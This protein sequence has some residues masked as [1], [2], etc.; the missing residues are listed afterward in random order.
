MNKYL[1]YL[2]RICHQAIVIKRSILEEAG[3]FDTSLAVT[4]DH[5]LILY[6]VEQFKGFK[7]PGVLSIY[8]GGGYSHQQPV[9]DTERRHFQR[10][11]S[12]HYSAIEL[13]ILNPLRSF[14]DKLAAMKRNRLKKRTRL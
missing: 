5:L 8:K 7:I 13:A 3:G 2:K 4:A 9:T 12:K 14:I 1:V 10:E 6:T 11:V